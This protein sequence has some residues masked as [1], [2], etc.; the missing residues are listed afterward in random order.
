MSNIYQKLIIIGRAT[1]DAKLQK[2]KKG[3]VEFATLGVAVNEGQDQTTFFDVTVFNRQR[4][5]VSN[6]VTKGRMVGVDGRISR[7]NKGYFN[8]VA[9][10]VMFLDS[11]PETKTR[12]KPASKQVKNTKKSK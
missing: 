7:G 6:H 5:A 1:A 4:I 2:S 10:R 9:N 12:T 8:V 3:D 11:P